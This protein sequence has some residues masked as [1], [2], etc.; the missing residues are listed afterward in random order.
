MQYWSKNCE[1]IQKWFFQQLMPETN[2]LQS[3]ISTV[4]FNERGCA[5]FKI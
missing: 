4:N 2:F 5:F 3:I 1:N